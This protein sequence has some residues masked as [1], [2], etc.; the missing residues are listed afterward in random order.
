[1]KNERPPKVDFVFIGAQKSG[2]TWLYESLAAHP[3]IH[4]GH[5]ETDKDTQFFSAFYDRGYEWYE[6]WFD[7]AE[8]G[9]TVGEISTSYLPTEGANKRIFEYNKNVKI[10]ACL[11][12]PV[13]RLISNHNHEIRQGHISGENLGL[14]NGI[15]N[16][17][18][19]IQQGLYG[20]W[21]KSWF[22]TFPPSQIRIIIFE[23]LFLDP[24][25]QIASLYE[26]LGVDSQYKPPML[27]QKI[28]ENS[29]PKSHGLNYLL[30]LS[31]KSLR[32]L[33]LSALVDLLKDNGFLE[34]V[35]RANTSHRKNV[36]PHNT[37]QYELA[38]IFSKDKILLESLLDKELTHWT[39]SKGSSTPS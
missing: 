11:R 3:K 31:G 10:V 29:I 6:S 14:M 36:R 34:K 12:D 1:M 18:S 30:K 32:K 28:N 39:E 19:Y 5:G 17:P 27:G 24:P 37:E 15:A 33:G 35:K 16:N 8:V 7:G 21:L 9:Q 26:F 25:A 13:T 23:E 4:I 22:E 20:H 2:S 38:E